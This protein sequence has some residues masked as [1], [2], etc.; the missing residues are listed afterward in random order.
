VEVRQATLEIVGR[1]EELEAVRAFAAAERPGRALLL[2][3]EPGIGKTTLWEA[4]V[5]AARGRGERILSTRQNEAE[6]QFSFAGLADLLADVDTQ[7]LIGVPAP[8]RSALEIALLR[9][10]PTDAPPESF[11]ISSGFLNTLRSLSRRDPLVLAIDDV[12]WLDRSSADVL[13]FAARRLQELPVRL[14]LARRPGD[15]SGLERALEPLGLERYEVGP[16]SL[17][18]ARVLLARRLGLA[19]S[20]R[21]LRRIVETAQGNPLLMLEFGRMLSEAGMSD[22]GSELPVP[23]VVENLFGSRVA[24]A[25]LRVRRLV[26]ALALGGDLS[27]AELIGLGSVAAIDDGVDEGL[28]VVDHR[29]V[30]VSH[31]LLAAAVQAHSSMR[32]R[33]R[34]HRDLADALADK[35]RRALHLALATAGSNA[36]LAEILAATAEEAMAR[37][38][39]ADAV[40]LADHA[41]RLTPL[42]A[43]VYSERLLT[44]AGYLEVSGEQSRITELLEPRLDSLPHGSARARGHLLLADL[45]DSSDEAHLEHAFEE[46]EDDPV[47]RAAV[48]EKQVIVVSGVHAERF[49]DA[50]QWL[51]D[52]V[53]SARLGG[54]D[55][56]RLVVHT[57]AWIRMLRGRPTK[58]LIDRLA[59]LARSPL[60]KSSIDHLVAQYLGYRGSVDEARPLFRQ[61]MALADER[62]ESRYIRLHYQLCGLE[63]RAGDTHAASRLLAESNEWLD[64][65]HADAGTARY[66]TLLA[67]IRGLP[68]E[69]ERWAS[70]AIEGGLATGY[71]WSRL[72]ALRSLGLASLLRGQPALAAENLRLVWEHA[73]REGL[74]NP[75]VFP[76]AADLVEALAELGELDEAAA[77]TDRLKEL[78]EEQEHPWALASV[79]RCDVL[80]KVAAG[81]LDE[82]AADS[83]VEAAQEYRALGLRFDWARSLLIL[84]RA[85]RRVRR[86]G[87]ARSLLELAA[88]GFD[89]LG[90]RGWAEHTRS[91]LM[92]V[93]GRRPTSG[94]ELT[95]TEQR[96]VELAVEGLSNKEIAR[97]LFVAVHTVEVHLSHAYRKL[98]VRSRAQLARSLASK[99]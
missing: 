80:I 25:P 71:T 57:L 70:A 36:Q 20:R 11:A 9:A 54:A 88:A 92:R 15:V 34:M 45:S 67:A 28:L 26:L 50:E 65:R 39:A 24:A 64:S 79:K 17:G 96:V 61:L 56:E 32:E 73:L 12:P 22:M 86:W 83:L 74:D 8:Q 7:E 77:A 10:E 40:E 59:Q 47:L 55:V 1:E 52:T 14:L 82:L 48:I 98:G 85:Q 46:T 35:T 94:R 89:D 27:W 2:T 87:A 84:G 90:S 5:E 95:P 33:R 99:P 42:G 13:V 51:S 30:R 62:G 66:E 91:E 43:P 38:A 63:L 72:D 21:T 6:A 41:L 69:T 37:G 3:G 97:T 68:D 44:L 53:A 18:A 75:G 81:G 78:G 76:V 16:L 19:L 49:S 31:P 58:E 23:R 4:G 60:D 93:G 29:R